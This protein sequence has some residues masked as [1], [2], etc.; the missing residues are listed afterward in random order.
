MECRRV[1][2]TRLGSSSERADLV[3]LPTPSLGG[4]G[5]RARVQPN[6]PLASDGALV[7]LGWL[8]QRDWVEPDLENVA[9]AGRGALEEDNGCDD[10]SQQEAPQEPDSNQYDVDIVGFHSG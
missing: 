2:V 6:A 7:R 10:K 9:A 4:S 8:V 1:R 5:P 3:E